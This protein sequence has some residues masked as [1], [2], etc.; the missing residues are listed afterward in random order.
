MSKWAGKIGFVTTEEVTPGDWQPVIVEKR[1]KGDILQNYRKYEEQSTS[2][3]DDITI[4]N[5]ISVV[6]NLY[7][8]NHI[9]EMKYIEFCGALWKIKSIDVQRP[10]LILT[11]GGVWNA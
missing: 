10:R 4:S 11:V 1:Y 5:R 7:A 6:A 3:N 8:Y 9:S 2:T